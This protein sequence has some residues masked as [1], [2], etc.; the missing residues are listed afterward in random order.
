MP[1][2]GLDSY[3]ATSLWL[4]EI[5]A[6]LL[7]VFWRPSIGVYLLIVLLPLQTI[8]YR[9]HGYFLGDQ[10]IDLLLLGAILGLIRLGEPVFTKTP[11]NRLLL[12]YIVYTYLSMFRG[13]FFLGSDLP[14]W[15]SDPRVSEWKNYVVDLL[16]MFMVMTNTIRTKRQMGIVII[17]M[18]C[19]CLLLGKG[20][21]NNV[22]DRDFSS[23]SYDLRD[24]GPMGFAGV[25][26][27]AAFSAQMAMLLSALC[28][29]SRRLLA[30]FGYLGVIAVCIYC[31]TF[32]LSRGGYLAFIVGLIF[33]GLIRA[34]WLLVGLAA[35][36][37]AWQGIV[38]AAVRD[39]VF[40][41]TDSEGVV[42]HS[43]AARLSLWEEGMRV[44]EGDPIFGTGFNTYMYTSHVG[45]YSDTHNV[46][47]KVL[48]ETGLSG[49][50]LFVAIYWKLFQV[51]F[52]L[53]RTADDPFFS[54]IGL[55]LAALMVAVVIAN[56]FGDRWMY[57][58]ITGYTFA[59]AAMAVRSQKL[60]DESGAAADEEAASAELVD[61]AYDA[62]GA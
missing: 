33:I 16:V 6:F 18:C 54:S 9:V 19:G 30:K 28:L 46:Y 13:S 24:A 21:H 15:F 45:G 53:Y 2:L 14:L 58:Q 27:L 3:A 34:R 59:A 39:R 5:I 38:P 56:M 42:E 57:F 55:G 7:S 43:A 35:F 20:F 32:A 23:F 41:T 52:R 1:H 40:M 11:L 36:L 25:N 4:A 37:L 44:F 26:G 22:A 51:G 48:V 62:T 50:V 29:G 17:C 60:S 47:V 10:F 61:A 8:R 12:I 49:L 31:L